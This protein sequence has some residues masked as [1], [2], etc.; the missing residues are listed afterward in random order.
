MR[1][2]SFFV[3]N[4]QFTL[5]LLAMLVVISLATLL[6]MPRSEDPNI[7]PPQYPIVAIYPGT[8]PKD[9]EEL[10]VKPIEKKVSE[11]ENIKK[12]TTR[13][14]DGVA[15][16]NVEYN[17]DADVEEKYQE[18]VR[19]VNALRGELPQDLYS[20]EVNKVSPTDVSVLQVAL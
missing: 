9:I 3:K 16:I 6:T 18:L 4:Y 2:T 7:N 17:Y 10:V 20:L 13:I 15:V 12:I 8:S 5:V 14:D 1:F 19:E 11:L